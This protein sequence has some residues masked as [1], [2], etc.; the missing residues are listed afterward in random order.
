M[1]KF[2][3]SSYTK[4]EF[5]NGEH[6]FEH[7]YR[8]NTV[9]FITSKVSNA[10]KAFK[11]DQAKSIFWDRF[12]FYVNK[13]RFTPWIRTLMDNHYHFLGYLPHG[14]NL[15]PLMQ[16]LHGSVAKLVNDTLQ[17]RVLPF[18][19]TKGNKDYFDGCIRNETQL[20][21]AFRYTLMQSVRAG[22]VADYRDYAHTIMDVDLKTAVERAKSARVYLPEIPYPRYDRKRERGR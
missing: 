20:R 14:E 1:G 19:R 9:Y 16:R 15:G 6:R 10:S 22:I 7:W 13:Y 11:S 21:R 8:D 12:N 5:H 2:R 3:S 18:W 17:S 4:R